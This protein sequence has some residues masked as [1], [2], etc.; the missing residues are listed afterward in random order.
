MLRMLLSDSVAA[1]EFS[2]KGVDR[3]FND[4]MYFELT[5]VSFDAHLR[6]SA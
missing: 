6:K 5:G 3:A 2:N 4:I 1:R